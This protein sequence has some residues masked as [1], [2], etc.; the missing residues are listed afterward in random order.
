MA[1]L[2]NKPIAAGLAVQAADT[3]RV[4]MLQRG[5]ESD[6][7]NGNWEFPG[8]HIE[9][10]ESA[11]TAAKREWREETGMRLPRGKLV[12]LWN[13]GVYRG[14]VYL[15]DSESK[16]DIMSDRSRVIHNDPDKDHLE[17]IAWW[18]PEQLRKNP[19]VRP[20]LRKAMNQV[21]R[22]LDRRFA[23]RERREERLTELAREKLASYLD[24]NDKL[25]FW[26][27]DGIKR[28]WNTAKNYASAVV[29]EYPNFFSQAYNPWHSGHYNNDYIDRGLR[30]ASQASMG[31][32]LTAAAL[33]GAIV[34]GPAAAGSIP[35]VSASRFIPGAARF[36]PGASRLMGSRYLSW[37]SPKNWSI[38]GFFRAAS[39]AGKSGW[40]KWA[41]DKGM[42]GLNYYSLYEI[43]RGAWNWLRGSSNSG[44]A[45][46][47]YYGAARSGSPP[48]RQSM[49]Y[50][51]QQ[52]RAAQPRGMYGRSMFGDMGGYGETSAQRVTRGSYFRNTSLG[53]FSVKTSSYGAPPPKSLQVFYRNYQKVLQRKAK[54]PKPASK[55]P[56]P[57]PP[58]PPP[59]AIKP[60]QVSAH[61]L[62]RDK[63]PTLNGG[64][65]AGVSTQ[66]LFNNLTKAVTAGP[67]QKFSPPG[68][69][70][71]QMFMRMNQ[72]VINRPQFSY[73]AIAARPNLSR[74]S[75]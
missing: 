55:P 47:P 52:Q 1:S 5:G 13:A 33:L 21:Q 62:R 19:A 72:P 40:V 30:R 32:G 11:L 22:A 42:R 9:P 12:A 8:G 56:A 15:I 63:P 74:V 34:L 28:G 27:W 75:R 51:Y 57:P 53:D 41:L 6:P 48:F 2:P 7:N 45:S 29:Q 26:P 20:E 68:P 14:F 61:I 59:P 44:A 69:S 58:P 4:L 36:I 43:G 54:P 71:W 38:P 25:A 3:G 64:N 66:N 49:S 73:E 39:K 50:R 10:G 70:G 31:V 16:L 37:A 46:M 67:E 17:A 35:A 24:A 23:N 18:S 60:P 65:F